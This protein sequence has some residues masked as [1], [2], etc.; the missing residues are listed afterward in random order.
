M[1]VGAGCT[2]VAFQASSLPRELLAPPPPNVDAIMLSNLADHRVNLQAIQP[3]DVLELTMLTD[4]SEMRTTITPMRVAMDGTVLV[5]LI[6]KVK[7]GGMEAEAAERVI[8]DAGIARGLF[9]DPCLT[10]TVKQRRVNRVTV[11]GAVAQPG[12]HEL[13]QVSSSLLA[14][15]VAA[16]G[17][18]KDASADVEIRHLPV[19]G[20]Q[21]RG[22]EPRTAG[23]PAADVQP[24]GYQQ[25]APAAN[26]YR[27][28]LF[29]LG[30]N[31]QPSPQLGDGDVVQVLK[32]DMR[33]IYV[34]GLVKKAGEF[35]LPP[36]HAMRLLDAVALAGDLS[37]PVADKVTILRQLPGQPGALRIAATLGA[38]RNGQDNLVLAPGDT[39]CVEQT[40]ATVVVDTVQTFFR[41][42]FSA[43]FPTF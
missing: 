35:D 40:A 14:A 22:E 12:V 23:G 7:V 29:R 5:P 16:G 38:A 9:R 4:F 42:G 36:N 32:H 15:V 21:G 39:I 43:A 3:D 24:A 37:N 34:T 31:G 13:P 41:V 26:S 30:E 11:V 27:V 20:E 1:V 17:L 6:G 33:P 10:L 2:P 28:N 25:A 18:T 8:A 19:P